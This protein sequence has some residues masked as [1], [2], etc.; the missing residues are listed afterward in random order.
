MDLPVFLRVLGRFKVLTASGFV[1]ALPLTVLSTVS[2]GFHNGGIQAHYRTKQQWVSRGTVLVTER[3]FPLGRSF[4]DDAIPTT[5][6]V[7][8]STPSSGMVYW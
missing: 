3:R 2:V 7:I 4:L 6:A 5:S 8:P 1:L